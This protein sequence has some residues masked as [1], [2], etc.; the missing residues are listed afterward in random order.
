MLR[1]RPTRWLAVVLGAS[2]LAEG[3]FADT[4]VR[5]PAVVP[6]GLIPA[7]ALVLDLP[8][9]FPDNW[10]Y[11]H[12]STV[13]VGRIQNF[14]NWSPDMVPDASKTCL[15]LEYFCNTGDD[16]CSL[17]DARPERLENGTRNHGRCVG[18]PLHVLEFSV[19][20]RGG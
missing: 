5:V 20:E 6:R 17:T 13:N 1:R 10:I 11:I 19:A 3:V 7:G 9:V 14:K 4:I 16:L 2:V 12:D 18:A 15:G 8:D